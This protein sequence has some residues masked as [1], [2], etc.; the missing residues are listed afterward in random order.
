MLWW[1]YPVLRSS[2]TICHQKIIE[3]GVSLWIK[4]LD[5]QTHIELC[6]LSHELP[7]HIWHKP[8]L[9]Y[10]WPTVIFTGGMLLYLGYGYCYWI[11]EAVLRM[12]LRTVR[13]AFQ[14][15]REVSISMSATTREAGRAVERSINANGNQWLSQCF[16]SPLDLHNYTVIPVSGTDLKKL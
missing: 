15:S 5:T 14:V 4:L 11:Y 8:L 1:F 3:G 6:T 7:S 9:Q 13:V 16:I 12:V 2:V 10:I